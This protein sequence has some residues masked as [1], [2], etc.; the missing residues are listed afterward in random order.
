MIKSNITTKTIL[1]FTIL[2]LVSISTVQAIDGNYQE[3]MQIRRLLSATESYLQHVPLD[4]IQDPSVTETIVLIYG[5]DYDS[6]GSPVTYY[7]KDSYPN[8]YYLADADYLHEIF[9]EMTTIKL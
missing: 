8:Y 6:N 5:A 3:A 9:W 2:S 4:E 7:I 1:T